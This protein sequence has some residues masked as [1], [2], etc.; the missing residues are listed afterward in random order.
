V[1]A[2]VGSGVISVHGLPKDCLV[3]THRELDRL[4]D[5]RWARISPATASK[6]SAVADNPAPGQTPR[7]VRPATT[8]GT[9]TDKRPLTSG[10]P[11]GNVPSSAPFAVDARSRGTAR[12]NLDRSRA[13]PFGADDEGGAVAHVELSLSGAFVPQARTPAEA[14]FVSSVER[15]TITVATAPS[16]AWSS[17]GHHDP[18][19]LAVLQR[20]ARARQAGRR[21]RPAVLGGVLG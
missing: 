20:A 17:T 3:A 11:A 13:G 18:R 9:A 4:L 19:R 5:R 16:P 14:E 15:W 2:F 21:G 6:L 10:R 8:A 1:L 7:T 12:S